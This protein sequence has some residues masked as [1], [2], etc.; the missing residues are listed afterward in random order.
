MTITA[1]GLTK[2]AALARL[3]REGR[4]SARLVASSAGPARSTTNPPRGT[5][6]TAG[7]ANWQ[8]GPGQCRLDSLNA[9]TP[10]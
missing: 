4:I 7:T 10:N 8:A 5:G 9:L 6:L 3:E 1:T 2:A